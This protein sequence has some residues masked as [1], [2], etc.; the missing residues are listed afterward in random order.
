[1]DAGLESERA[2]QRDS[3]SLD[4]LL[5]DFERAGNKVSVAVLDACRNNRATSL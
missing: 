4:E 1:L 3:F 2:L 5:G